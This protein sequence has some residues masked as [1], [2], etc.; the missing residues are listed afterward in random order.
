VHHGNGTQHLF[1][2]RSDVLYLSSHQFPF[3]PGSGAANEI[4]RGPGRGFTVNCP[5]P[6]GMGDAD[7][8]HV[9][10]ALFLPILRAYAPDFVIVSAGYDAHARDPIGE[11]RL[12]ERGYA[13]LTAALVGLADELC[14]GRVVFLLEGGYHLGALADSVTASVAVLAGEREILATGAGREAREA[15]A[16]TWAALHDTPLVKRPSTPVIEA[17][18]TP[19]PDASPR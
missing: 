11:M 10:S 12:G 15:V 9:F 7:F 6:A 3:Y 13:A 18:A 19:E 2:E 4:G 8:G 5:L 16:A 17:A 14:G 1:A